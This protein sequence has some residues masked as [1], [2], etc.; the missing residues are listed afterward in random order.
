MIRSRPKVHV[1]IPLPPQQVLEQFRSA[2]EPQDALC[3]GHVGGSELSLTVRDADQHIWSP[4]VSLE[5][6]G[7][8]SGTTLH[9]NIGPKPQLWSL[10]V[11]IYALLV[12]AFIGSTVYAIVQLTLNWPLTG[13][14]AAAAALVALSGACSVDLMGRRQSEAQRDTLHHFIDLALNGGE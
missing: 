3:Q 5:V 4:W 1:E 10:F 12:F 11:A 14:G 13:V 8:E 7:S 9:G 6:R 2:L